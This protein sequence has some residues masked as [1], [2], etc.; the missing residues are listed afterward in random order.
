MVEGTY[1]REYSQWKVFTV[2]SI[3]AYTVEGIYGGGYT[4]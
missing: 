4:W 2:E 3:H 1:G